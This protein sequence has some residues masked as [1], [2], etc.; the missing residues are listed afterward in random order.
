MLDQHKTKRYGWRPGLPDIRDKKFK[1]TY[2]RPIL[3]PPPKADLRDG[4]P[5]V[6]DQGELGSCTANAIAAAVDYAHHRTEGVFITP[7]RLFI[8]YGERVMEGDV[9]QDAGAEIKDG[10]Q[11]V[12][13]IGCPPETDWPYD[14]AQFAVQPDTDVYTSALAD[15][16]KEY[17]SLDLTDLHELMY[18][19]A[20]KEPF[21]FGFTVYENFEGDDVARTRIM[22]M[23]AGRIVGGHAVMACGYFTNGSHPQVP[24]HPSG[25]YF[26]VRNS[27]GTAWGI[28]GHFLMPFSYMTSP[29]LTA[30]A[31]HVSRVGYATV[32]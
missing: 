12:H 2:I 4:C 10:I 27:W 14:I 1:A 9:D 16:V 13:K 29:D 23:P 5:P 31:W 19:L 24:H 18:C 8:Y 32:A 21:V 3:A 6:Y 11:V 7:S 20:G 25:G 30:D 15:L 22:P 26:L 28:A 17:A